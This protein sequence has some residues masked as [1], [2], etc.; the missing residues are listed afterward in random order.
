MKITIEFGNQ[1]VSE[2]KEGR[3]QHT[4]KGSSQTTVALEEEIP[5]QRFGSKQEGEDRAAL[6]MLGTL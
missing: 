6:S 4:S 5:L 3:F 1:K 2:T